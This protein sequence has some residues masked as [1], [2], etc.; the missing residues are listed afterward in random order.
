MVL[1]A[2]SNGVEAR[3]FDASTLAVVGEPHLLSVTAAVTTPQEA[4]MLGA[5]G[6]ALAVAARP[7][8]WGRVLVSM[9]L[10]GTERRVMGGQAVTSWTRLSPD[11]RRLVRHRVD[12]DTGATDIWVEDL[13]RGAKLRVT[14]GRDMHVSPTWSPQGDRIAYRAGPNGAPHLAIAQADG[15]GAVTSIACPQ[16][17]CEPTD[18]SADGLRLLVNAGSDVFEVPLEP[19]TAARPLLTTA[20]LER[21]ARYS[22]D[23]RWVVYVSDESGRPEV[24]I[25][26]L[27]GPAQRIVVS[28]EGGDQPVWQGD[29]TAIFYVTGEGAL[30]RVALRPSGTGL[31]LERP[32]RTRV[33]AFPTGHHWGT[34]Y[35]VSADGARLYVLLPPQDGAVQDLTIIL[36]WRALLQVP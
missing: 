32:Q 6:E 5:S 2:R 12:P 8:P 14:T 21:D 29:G 17:P 7:V 36:G 26:S 31:A 28:N 22:P 25:R 9:S 24:S 27:K 23:G 13:D 3:A 33:P 30:H 10:D 15:S 19:S 1:T 18:W 35:D 20:S 4:A 34:A 11:G 16:S